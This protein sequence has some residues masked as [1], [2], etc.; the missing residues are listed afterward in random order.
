LTFNVF[1]LEH[2]SDADVFQRVL[3]RTLR[4]DKLKSTEVK[5]YLL[6]I[7]Q[8]D[9]PNAAIDFKQEWDKAFN[10]VNRDRMQYQAAL[11][12]K[13]RLNDLEQYYDERLVLRGKIIANKP[14]I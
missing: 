8:R 14:L 13:E 2:V 9:M 1:R 4:L 7:F 5:E 12:S 11:R 6:Q 3:T 10:E